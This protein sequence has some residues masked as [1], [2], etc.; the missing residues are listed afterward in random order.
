[1]AEMEAQDFIT[2][3]RKRKGWM[4]EYNSRRNYSL[5]LRVFELIMDLP[6]VYGSLNG[7]ARN[8]VDTMNDVFDIYTIAEWVEQRVYPYIIEVEKIQNDS[9]S[10][11]NVVSWESRPLKPLEDLK[12]IGVA[13]PDEL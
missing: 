11:M 2:V 7:I 4:T 6:K 10:L 9:V 8:A 5:P 3:T 13:I 1:M 12:R